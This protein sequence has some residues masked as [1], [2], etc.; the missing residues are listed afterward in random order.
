MRYRI[1]RTTASYSE[2]RKLLDIKCDTYERGFDRGGARGDKGLSDNRGK[3]ESMGAASGEYFSVA[4]KT[5]VV[6]LVITGSTSVFTTDC[7]I[8]RAEVFSRTARRI[9]LG[10]F[11]REKSGTLIP[12]KTR[13]NGIMRVMKRM[14]RLCFTNKL[15]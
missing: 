2:P 9:G 11:G 3:G 14:Q 13:N 4:R 15:M 12:A 6:R 8:V 5:R 10:L 1:R 7:T